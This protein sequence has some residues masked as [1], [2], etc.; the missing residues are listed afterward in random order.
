MKTGFLPNV[1]K[2]TPQIE[3][4]YYYIIFDS[5]FEKAVTKGDSDCRI[6]AYKINKFL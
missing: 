4:C 2:I 1:F 5:N 3:N 6:P